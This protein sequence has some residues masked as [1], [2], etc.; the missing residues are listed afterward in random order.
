MIVDS[1]GGTFVAGVVQ[2]LDNG[3]GVVVKLGIG[4]GGGSAVRVVRA[5]ELCPLEPAG[6]VG[7][8]GV[9]V[10]D[11]AAVTALDVGDD[12][13]GDGIGIEANETDSIGGTNAGTV[14]VQADSRDLFGNTGSEIDADDAGLDVGVTSR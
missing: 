11:G 4:I 14:D 8:G 13:V 5:G 2:A 10:A 9:V 6:G 7:E 3:G 12:V 1:L